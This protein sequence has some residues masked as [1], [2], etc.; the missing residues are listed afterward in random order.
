[1]RSVMANHPADT[2]LTDNWIDDQVH[3]KSQ[4]GPVLG[5]HQRFDQRSERLIDGVVEPMLLTR[6]IFEA[7]DAGFQ[8]HQIEHG[9]LRVP[10]AIDGFEAQRVA[11]RVRESLSLSPRESAEKAVLEKRPCAVMNADDFVEPNGV[12]IPKDA[13]ERRIFDAPFNRAFL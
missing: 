8:F 3:C 10:D 4:F 11:D 13:R 1:M 6:I 7:L 12:E 2:D 5:R 9:L